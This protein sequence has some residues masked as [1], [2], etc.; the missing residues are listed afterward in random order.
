M[1]YGDSIGNKNPSGF[2][3]LVQVFQEDHAVSYLPLNR[4]WR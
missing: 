1:S 4:I 2:E 3:F